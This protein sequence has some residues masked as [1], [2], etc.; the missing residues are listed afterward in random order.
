MI[1]REMHHSISGLSHLTFFEWAW[2]GDLDVDRRTKICVN[3][4]NLSILLNRL[5]SFFYGYDGG[6]LLN[7]F[8]I[9]ICMGV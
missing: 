5:I 9:V 4:I 8:R 1:F 3:I 2:G 6:P 7:H